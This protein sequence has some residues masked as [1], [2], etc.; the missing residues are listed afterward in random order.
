MSRFSFSGLGC[1]VSFSRQ[2]GRG[3]S[4]LQFRKN[5][6]V[7]D[8][9]DVADTGFYIQK[10]KVK[11][12][13]LSDEGKEAVIAILER[14]NSSAKAAEWSKAVPRNHDGDGRLLDHGNH[15]NH[16]DRRSSR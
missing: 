16:D 5:Q 10:R 11:L 3:E 15:E 1:S 14:G 9:S 13:V 8:Q 2:C 6:Y 4:D 7:F 12:T